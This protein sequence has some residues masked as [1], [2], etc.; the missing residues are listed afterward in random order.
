MS[1]CVERRKIRVA[2]EDEGNGYERGE[3]EDKHGSEERE[4]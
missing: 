2:E 4:S 3:A 1:P